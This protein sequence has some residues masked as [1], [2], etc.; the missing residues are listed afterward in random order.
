[1]SSLEVNAPTVVAEVFE[2]EV[3]VIDLDR[4]TYYS[5]GGA[6]TRIWP[7]L[8]LGLGAPAIAERIATAAGGGEAVRGAVEGFLD[9]LMREGL[10]RA[11]QTNGTR[12]GAVPTLARFV[13]E[14]PKMEKFTDMQ[15]LIA[16]DPVHDV[17]DTE[18]WPIRVPLGPESA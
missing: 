5:L 16:L 13:F 1:M 11:A 15:E 9:E 6:A 3:V 2:Q 12:P 8:G 18:G 4:G 17:S 7:L 14:S 10:V